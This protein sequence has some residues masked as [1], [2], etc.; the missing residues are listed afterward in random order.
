MPSPAGD[1]DDAVVL[2]AH[3]LVAV[4]VDDGDD[5]FDGMGVAVVVGEHANP[6]E[7][8]R[9]AAAAVLFK[10]EVAV[11]PRVE[12]GELDVGDVAAGE[13]GDVVGVLLDGGD[14]VYQLG[15]GHA[16]LGTGDHVPGDDGFGGERDDGL[17]DIA[18]VPVEQGHERAAFEW[19]FPEP[20]RRLAWSGSWRAVEQKTERGPSLP[21]ARMMRATARY[22]SSVSGSSGWRAVS[23]RF[24]TLVMW[25]LL[26][27]ARV[28]WELGA[29]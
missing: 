18:G 26:G 3:D 19:L 2:D 10:A 6:G 14:G 13:G 12:H 16:G 20:A 27:R 5:A 25:R 29:C 17:D 1:I 24:A 8:A 22:S 23:E 21:D 7:D 15:D 11:G 9:E 28:S 4:E